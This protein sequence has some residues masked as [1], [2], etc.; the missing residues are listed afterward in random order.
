MTQYMKSQEEK[1]LEK[2]EKWGGKG[3]HPSVMKKDGKYRNFL[4]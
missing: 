4:P 2:F 1:E 3:G